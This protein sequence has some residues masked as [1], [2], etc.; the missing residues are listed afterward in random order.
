L[1]AATAATLLILPAVFALVQR[2]APNR[3]AS[4]DPL[5]PQSPQYR[6]DAAQLLAAE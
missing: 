6:S 4:L 2:Q 1:I 5:D 3:S